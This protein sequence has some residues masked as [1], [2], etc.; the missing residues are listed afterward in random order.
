MQQ[1]VEMA[2]AI[3]VEIVVEELNE[4]QKPVEIALVERKLVVAELPGVV[5]QPPVL[6][7][8]AIGSIV[9]HVGWPISGHHVVAADGALSEP[10][11]A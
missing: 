9:E 11:V 2:A 10:L 8:A 7:A 6:V 4:R 5:V 3:E 1:A